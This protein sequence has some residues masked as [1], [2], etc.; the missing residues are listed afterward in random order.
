[1]A[2]GLLNML[3]ANMIAIVRLK[4]T[5]TSIFIVIAAMKPFA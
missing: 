3:Y 1:M 4:P 2:Q 5:D